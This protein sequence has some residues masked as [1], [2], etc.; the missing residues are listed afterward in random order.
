MRGVGGGRE[1]DRAD[2]AAA[3][4]WAAP[5]LVKDYARQPLEALYQQY[6]N[7]WRSGFERFA[8]EEQHAIAQ[9]PIRPV[10][11]MLSIFCLLKQEG[12]DDSD[13]IGIGVV[14]SVATGTADAGGG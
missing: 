1:A 6:G 4:F 3:S 5:E 10:P 14:G 11:I 7:G 2:T 9:C 13:T 12:E 8:R